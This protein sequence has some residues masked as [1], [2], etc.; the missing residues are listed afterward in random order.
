MTN[1]FK[2]HL[3]ILVSLFSIGLFAQNNSA[4]NWYFGD[5]AAIECSSG[6]PISLDNSAM[7]AF[8]GSASYSDENGDLLFYTNGMGVASSYGAVYNKNHQIMPNG[9]I[10]GIT[11]NAS[12]MQS[13][14]FVP[15]PGSTTSYYL[16]TLDGVENYDPGYK[17]LC[18]SIVDMTLDGGLGDLTNVATPMNVPALP[19]LTEQM[20]VTK[21]ANGTDYWL[22]VH[23]GEACGGSCPHNEFFVYHISST[24]IVGLPSQEIGNGEG[25]G[26]QGT[27]KIS[28]QGDRIAFS[29]DVFDF[30][31]STGII[32][33]PIGLNQWGYKAFSQS[34]RFLYMCA[35]GVRIFQFDLAA[36]DIAA[37]KT[38]IASGTSIDYN[39][40]Q[41]GPDGK[42]YIAMDGS[43]SLSVINYPDVLGSGCDF[44]YAQVPLISGE[45]QLGL[46]NFIDSELFD[47][48]GLGVQESEELETKIYPTISD[49]TISVS[50]ISEGE[51][52]IYDL[53]GMLIFSKNL[54]GPI[55]DVNLFVSAGMY[56]WNFSENGKIK[57][58][59]IV[60]R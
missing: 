48:I 16:F 43:A 45:S 1:S 58:G 50:G 41:I 25:S 22:I 8:E 6:A 15:M 4:N 13:S 38:L 35:W 10:H 56:I 26:N 40:M 28:V 57:A 19:F 27:L 59:K 53:T 21:H 33:N 39:Q 46:P 20:A 17:G 2:H 9:D 30:D 23:E 60:I 7:R 3:A 31:N 42:I 51:L 47:K 29:Y 37:S 32:S 18:Y 5:S 24:G 36:T 54:I 34:G 55:A 11:G 49:G 52:R 44:V 14:I 12:T